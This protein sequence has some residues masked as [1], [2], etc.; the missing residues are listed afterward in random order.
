MLRVID[1]L[2]KFT[3]QIASKEALLASPHDK[4]KKNN[5]KKPHCFL[6]MH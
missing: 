2:Q 4:N 5:N 6:Y 3:N 1:V